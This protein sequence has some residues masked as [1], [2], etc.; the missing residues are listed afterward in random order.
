[1]IGPL[2][3]PVAVVPGPLGIGSGLV[4][5]PPDLRRGLRPFPAELR[6]LAGLL[7][8]V[9]PVDE[10]PARL[11]YP[12]PEL[13]QQRGIGPAAV[14][15]RQRLLGDEPVAALPAGHRQPADVHE[16]CPVAVF[17]AQHGEQLLVERECGVEPHP[18]QWHSRTPVSLASECCLVR[19]G[20]GR[21]S[22]RPAAIR[23]S[24]GPLVSAVRPTSSA[25]VSA[26]LPRFSVRGEEGRVSRIG[27]GQ[28]SRAWNARSS[29]G[30]TRRYRAVCTC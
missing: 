15:E 10:P 23:P 2:L 22:G 21:I 13:D 18:R 6:L 20:Y 30:G 8:L 7:E 16:R 1:M 24:P 19:A 29:R 14:R 9:P 28:A 11:R 27:R 17:A 4:P 25:R 5:V 12:E 3:L 26:S